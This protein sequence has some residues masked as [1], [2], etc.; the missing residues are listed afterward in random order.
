MLMLMFKKVGPDTYEAGFPVDWALGFRPWTPQTRSFAVIHRVETEFQLYVHDKG[1][2]HRPVAFEALAD[3]ERAASLIAEMPTR[4]F[5]RLRTIAG[6]HIAKNFDLPHPDAQ[7]LA[8]NMRSAMVAHYA[9]RHSLLE[10]VRARPALR[11]ASRK[12]RVAL[13]R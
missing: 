2:E 13:C 1:P 9:L 8:Q 7:K 4:E 12:P 11:V 10:A 6:N 3:A 5:A